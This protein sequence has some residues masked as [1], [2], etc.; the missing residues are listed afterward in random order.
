MSSI[1]HETI[2][3]CHFMRSGP[4]ASCS[5][6]CFRPDPPSTWDEPAWSR[7]FIRPRACF[8]APPSQNHTSAAC[9]AQ[10]CYL[11]LTAQAPTPAAHE[12]MVNAWS[13][14]AATCHRGSREGAQQCLALFQAV[15]R[16]NGVP[17]A[18]PW[19]RALK[20]E[21]LGGL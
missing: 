7:S 2:V 15:Q 19:V 12:R 6:A 13:S 17:D 10:G 1:L 4:Y 16:L 18:T 20:Q 3:Q 8:G 14:W 5:L 11:E 21:M 9:A